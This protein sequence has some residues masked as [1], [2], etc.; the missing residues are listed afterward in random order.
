[1]ATI[2]VTNINDSGAGSLRAALSSAQSGDI[3]VFDS[4]LTGQQITLT[5]GQL[6]I[7][8]NVT[9]DG[10]AASGV[11]ISGNN[12]SRVIDVAA[13]LNV[14]LKNLTI[15]DGHTTGTAM[16]GAGGGIRTGLNTTL[17]LEN[18]T[19]KNNYASGDGG[20]GLWAGN[21]STTTIT[22]ST[23]EGNSTAGLQAPGSV[24]ERGGGAIAVASESVITVSGSTFNNNTGINGGAIN[25]V[26]STLTVSGSTFTNNDTTPGGAFGPD[27]R[28]YGGAIYSDGGKTGVSDSIAIT[29]SRF[30]GNK[31]A[32]QGGAIFLYPYSGHDTASIS[33]STIVNN[34]VIKDAKGDSLGGGIRIGGGGGFTMTN[35]TVA[36]NTSNN[37][38]G[39]LW[40][41]EG[42]PIEITNSTFYG[43]RALSTNGIN[44]EGLGGAMLL[45]NNPPTTITSSTIAN[46]YA[47]FQG[48]GFWGGGSNTTINDS[49]ITSNQA[50]NNNQGWNI[51]HQTGVTYN[52]SGN[53]EYNPY[54]GNDTKVVG[55][56]QVVDP[57]LATFLDNGTALQSPPQPGNA[58]VTAGAD[59]NGA[60]LPTI[61][62][63][64][65]NLVATA[66]NDTEIALSWGDSSNNESG[67]KIERSLDNTNWSTVGTAASNSTSYTDTGLSANTQYYYRL[68]AINGAG[69]S[70]AIAADTTTTNTGIGG[71]PVGGTPI[72]GT[73][74]GGTPIGGTPVGGTPIGGTPIGGTPVS[75]TPGSN[76]VTPSLTQNASNIFTLV[77][78][79]NLLFALNGTNTQAVN[80]IAAFKVDDDRGTIN[81][82]APGE[83][84][85]LQ[86][87]L[88]NSKVIFSALPKIFPNLSTNRNI[89]F[90]SGDKL[91][92]YLVQ[93]GTT[94]KALSELA[95]GGAPDNVFFAN[96]SANAG[97]A[98]ALQTSDL[99][100]NR[101]RLAWEDRFGGSVDFGDL[102]MT[103][104]LSQ[105]PPPIATQLQGTNSLEV[106]DLTN[107][108][109]SVRAQFSVHSD[110]G[111]SNSFGFY[112]IDDA[113]GRIGDLKPGDAGYAQA[114]V[115]Q[116]IDLNSP[117]SGGQL[118]SPFLIANGTA[119]D[120]LSK[121]PGN[122]ANNGPNAYFGSTSANPDGVDH[123]RLIGDNTFAFEDLYG[124]GDKDYNDYVV[125]VNFA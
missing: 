104:E 62:L 7:A 71:T 49:L 98:S 114:A 107:L 64:P 116:R 103:V 111:Y 34:S 22:N 10:S 53:V 43:N 120:F 92:F 123:I 57:Q 81:G 18:S 26:L 80:E 46:N 51:N 55:S 47:A 100:N 65:T 54:N 74:I 32:G 86:A 2:A 15:A 20:G 42:S 16:D 17:V 89:S 119:D 72:G 27:T 78:G 105:A 11:T 56:S 48:G 112:A 35:T 1:M 75:G 24:G 88:S 110:A 58:T 12:A 61:P 19:L 106:L 68:S 25:T 45:A 95:S 36:N 14:T 38:G 109:S 67:F 29:T 122:Q 124:G 87:A 5:S 121:N 83:A 6:T 59:P 41:G 79:E 60:P 113:T 28:G 82:I 50:N 84:G 102:D 40:A 70:G 99:G 125:Q 91:G 37:Q 23:F 31:A 44:G 69:A 97:G 85:Y 118:L 115:S 77:G 101:Y 90:D 96:A 4:A 33:D 3:I 39:G 108:T 52:G 76:P 13:N 30:D 66:A 93:N 73:P 21:N 63:A 94:E 8:S 117:L 9:L